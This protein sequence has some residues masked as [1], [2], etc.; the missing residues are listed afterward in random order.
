VDRWNLRAANLLTESRSQGAVEYDV[1]IVS[2]GG[3]KGRYDY[4]PHEMDWSTYIS[5]MKNF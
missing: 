3:K 4:Y 1:I 2:S 5:N